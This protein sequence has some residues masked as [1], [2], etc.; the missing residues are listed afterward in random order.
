M[1]HVVSRVSRCVVIVLLILSAS[2]GGS[3]PTSPAASSSADVAG[4]WT[5]TWSFVASGVTVTDNVRAVFTIGSAGIA[6]HWTSDSGPTG[7]MTF[8]SLP[9][10]TNVSGTFTIQTMTLSGAACS[11]QAPMTGVATGITME[12][13]IMSIAGTATCVWATDHRF[14]LKKS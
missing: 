1:S 14:T 2:C 7:T 4:N 10:G 11:A 12:V 8:S 5:G 13:A 3:S 6:G 9:P